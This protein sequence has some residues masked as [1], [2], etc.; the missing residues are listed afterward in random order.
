[1]VFLFLALDES[2]SGWF[3]KTSK[4]GG[5]PNYIHESRK[6]LPLGIMLKNP[7]KCISSCCR[8]FVTS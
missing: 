7:V 1:M 2:I 4:L 8:S 3:P 6:L 5:L